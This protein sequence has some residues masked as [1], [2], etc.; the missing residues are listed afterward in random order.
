M[1]SER[2]AR[3]QRVQQMARI[4][5]VMV[6]LGCLLFLQFLLLTVALDGYLSGHGTV[7]L[8]AALASGLCCL[9]ACWLLRYLLLPARH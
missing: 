6:C 9:A 1:T 7:A 8:P 2:Q 5:T 3:A 4:Y